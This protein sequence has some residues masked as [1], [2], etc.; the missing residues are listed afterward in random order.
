[1][2]DET[3]DESNAKGKETDTPVTR[4]KK[5]TEDK[6]DGTLYAKTTAVVERLEKANEVTRTNLDRQ[7]KLESEKLLGGRADAGQETKPETQ[8]DRDQAMADKLL[9]DEDDN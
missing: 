2:S 3:T 5:T 4:D 8:D 6:P 7:E 9:A 1:M